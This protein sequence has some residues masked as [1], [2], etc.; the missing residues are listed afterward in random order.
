VL[1]TGGP[2]LTPWREKVAG[3]VEAWYPGQMGG[4]AI[5]RVLFGDVD[6]GGRLPATFPN[7]ERDIPTAGDKRKYPGVADRVDYLEETL[8]GYRWYDAK[9]IGPAF[10]FGFG[11]SYTSFRYGK[12]RAKP[13]KD[14]K[15]A[16]ITFDVVNTGKRRGIA[17]PQLYVGIPAPAAGEE[18]APRQLKGFARLDL[19][20]GRRK[21]VVLKLTERDLS[22]WDT[23]ANG[24]KVVPGCYPLAIG[25]SSRSTVAKGK[26]PVAGGRCT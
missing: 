8:V 24:W 6:P 4:P 14:G 5:S 11:L 17:V 25:R 21:R 23:S 16:R 22:S 20:P 18:Q 3:L 13:S 2:V 7:A 12:L 1:Q 9:K 26:L 10:P 15:G 19:K